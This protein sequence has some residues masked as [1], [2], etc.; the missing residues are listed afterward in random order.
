MKAEYDKE[1]DTLTITLRDARVKK[2]M[3][4][5][6]RLLPISVTMVAWLASKFC[7]PQKWSNKRANGVN[8]MSDMEGK[9]TR[10]GATERGQRRSFKCSSQSLI[11]DHQ[12]P[13]QRG[14]C[15]L[16]SISFSTTPSKAWNGRARRA[17]ARKNFNP[18]C[19]TTMWWQPCAAK[20]AT[21]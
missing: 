9:A 7:K 2:V 15:R 20:K 21:T 16:R 14:V 10:V 13:T 12:Q 5:V 19:D 3:R 6:P 17:R 8:G 1:T 4:F 18:S 11:T